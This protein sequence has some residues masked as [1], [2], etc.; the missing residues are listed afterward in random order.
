MTPRIIVSYDDTAND[1][2]ALALGRLF[3][4]AGAEVALAYVRHTQESEEA[5][6][7]LQEHEAEALLERGAAALGRDVERHVVMSVSTGEGLSGLAERT[8]ADGVVFGSDY[9]TPVGQVAPQT[10]ARRLLEGGPA[11]VALAPAGLRDQGRVSVSKVGL[12][13]DGGDP[14]AE[15]T[16]RSLA[17][18]VG[19]AVAK[20]TDEKLDLLV[21]G[22]RP[23]ASPGRVTVSAATE[24]AIENAACPVLVVPR[25]VA[26]TFG[27]PVAA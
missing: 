17:A 19:G 15:Q 23:E 2:D 9:R 5:A 27:T 1:Q 22:S 14:G 25:G 21:V 16:A 10:S 12:I 6:E 7:R 4:D 26:V 13:P 18:A 11:A 8:H 3:A 24:Y 20:S